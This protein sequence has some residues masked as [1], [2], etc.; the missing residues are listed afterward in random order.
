MLRQL[1][2]C[3]PNILNGVC[4]HNLVLHILLLMKDHVMLVYRYCR[5]VST[6]LIYTNISN[7]T[8]NPRFE[9]RLLLVC[10]YLCINSDQRLLSCVQRI[11]LII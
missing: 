10:A 2:D 8:L 1:V 6:E 11:L 9:L 5:L 3:S 7:N 4:R